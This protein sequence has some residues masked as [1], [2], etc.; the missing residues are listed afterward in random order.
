[1]IAVRA[2]AKINL[3][4]KVQG[5]REDG[6]HEIN[7]TLQSIDL[8][9]ELRLEPAPELTL[10]V[11]G[12]YPVPADS[13]N[14]AMRAAAALSARH[15][16]RG[17]RILLIKRIPPGSGLGG[18]SSDAAATLMGL[19][20]LWET[21]SGPEA[22]YDIART[23]G[24]DVPFFLYGGTCLGVGRGDDLFPLPDLPE[25]QVL[26]V[27]TGVGL[28]TKEV[29][30]GLPESLTHGRNLSSMRGFNPVPAFRAPGDPGTFPGSFPGWGPA[31]ARSLAE[32]PRVDNDLEEASFARIPQLRWIK[33]RLLEGGA[34]A[35]A[36]SGSG[37]AVFGL[38][39]LDE[40]LEGIRT[41]LEREVLSV[42]VCRTLSRE[43]YGNRLL[44]LP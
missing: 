40:D 39:P 3:G 16:S 31:D 14:L 6:Y 10:R 23:L 4:L 34:V 15:G 37:S 18:G 28:S 17:A 21:R 24:S 30:A 44:V 12:D 20:R 35:A 27:W 22:L 32:A 25:R 8:H 29:Y 41:T 33:E 43:A 19:D 26:V 11:E 36:M 7:T 2:H 1:M 9:D 38:Y 5:L 42:F 13:S